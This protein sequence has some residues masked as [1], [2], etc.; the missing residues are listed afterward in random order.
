[1]MR[2]FIKVLERKGYKEIHIQL[3]PGKETTPSILAERIS[4]IINGNGYNIVR[5]TFFGNLEARSE[6]LKRL[7]DVLAGVNFPY[8]WIEGADCTGSFING[9][10]FFGVE[11]I[12][13]RRILKNGIATGSYFQ[14]SEAEYCFLAGLY[15]ENNLTPTRQ[16]ADI[17]NSADNI[18]SQAGM[19][20]KNTV[21]TW[22][23]LDDIPE[24]YMDFNT[25]RT[26]FFNSRG[27]A[28]DQIPA[29]TG[30]GGKN[31]KSSKIC[32]ELLAIKPMKNTF[33]IKHADSPLQ[34]SALKYG[35]S[36]SRAKMF[37]TVEHLNMTVSG[38]ASI[39][40]EGK[41]LHAGDM[42]KQVD[43]TLKVIRELLISHRFEFKD[44]VRAYA[45]FKD[46]RLVY[47]FQDQIKKEISDVVFICTGNKICRDDLLFE[48]DIDVAKRND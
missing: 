28:S 20:F 46:V 22:F 6:T 27:F 29:S 15:S 33:F 39:D 30:I 24:W 21:R 18:L 16:A 2:E 7:E 19:N 8:S 45:Y 3:V 43:M 13:V 31:F 35:S 25:A 26:L 44:I 11:G 12:K 4:E 32:L 1:M 47:G 14:T 37:G 40:H 17:L 34:C 48:M 9:A 10:Y 38:T 42:E 36:F 5:A 23:Y 41:T